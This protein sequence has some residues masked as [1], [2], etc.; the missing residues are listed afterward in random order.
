[1]S[2]RAV[3]AEV[4]SMPGR[5]GD[6]AYAALQINVAGFD[7]PYVLTLALPAIGYKALAEQADPIALYRALA[8]AVNKAGVALHERAKV[9]A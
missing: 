1:M 3:T 5:L 7:S 8:E 2:A 9:A 6:V 4:I